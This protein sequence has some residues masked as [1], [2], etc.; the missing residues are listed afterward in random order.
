MQ[1]ASASAGPGGL[2]S[3][4]DA[5]TENRCLACARKGEGK[6]NPFRY[7]VAVTLEPV[8]M[9]TM[10]IVLDYSTRGPSWVKR[11]WRKLAA[12]LLLLALVATPV[13]WYWQPIERW[14]RWQWTYRRVVAELKIE[15]DPD[16]A[17]VDRTRADALIAQLSVLDLR[18]ASLCID[19]SGGG[20]ASKFN[21][22]RILFAGVLTA[23]SGT[24]CFVVLPKGYDP[25]KM[26]GMGTDPIALDMPSLRSS[27]P[28]PFNPRV[29]WAIVA[30]EMVTLIKAVRRDARSI[31]VSYGVP[32]HYGPGADSNPVVR[33]VW[34]LNDDR[35]MTPAISWRDPWYEPRLAQR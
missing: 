21:P 5:G 20:A 12:L 8:T 15:T 24:T 28:S 11:H 9:P 32:N 35:S 3:P 23:P 31:E 4:C 29:A 7:A 13:W 19:N 30:P 14:A 34:T 26:L 33:V 27:G 25:L 18:I 2:C 16:A 17:L 1:I 6:K 10:G 22:G